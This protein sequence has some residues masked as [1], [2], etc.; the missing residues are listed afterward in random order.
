VF[1]DGLLLNA[2][3]VSNVAAGYGG[4]LYYDFEG[5]PYVTNSILYY[6]TATVG[7]NYYISGATGAFAHSCTTPAPDDSDT[8]T[9]DPAFV[10]TA[11]GDFRLAAASPCI[12]AGINCPAATG[13]TDCDGA[14]RIRFGIV[15]IGAFENQTA[16][17]LWCDFTANNTSPWVSN[18]VVFAASVDGTGT[19]TQ[20]TYA[21]D[22]D[23]SGTTSVAMLDTAL[24]TNVYCE[25]GSYSVALRVTNAA[26]AMAQCTHSNYIT[27]VPEPA[28]ALLVL[29]L[30]CA[31]RR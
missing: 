17:P 26:G 5:L 30:Y 9:N 12:N 7:D 23:G 19:L 18:P 14:P 4:G 25:L 15:D 29:V 10:N 3:L 22:F 16:I 27:V 13:L 31:Q 8:I 2:T 11:G 1:D 20:L 28:V 24:A 6:N 21:W